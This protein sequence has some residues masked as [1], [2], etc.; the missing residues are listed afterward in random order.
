LVSAGAEWGGGEKRV[1]NEREKGELRKRERLIEGDLLVVFIV[2]SG[3][4]E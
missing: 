3:E 4:V 2:D 1:V